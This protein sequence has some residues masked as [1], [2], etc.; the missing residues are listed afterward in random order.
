MSQRPGRHFTWYKNAWNLHILI[1]NF[2]RS[3]MCSLYSAHVMS[4]HVTTAY[5]QKTIIST[6]ITVISDH[7]SHAQ[8]LF[9]IHKIKM[10]TKC[11]C[12]FCNSTSSCLQ[13]H[14]SSAWNLSKL[15]SFPDT[16]NHANSFNWLGKQM[17]LLICLNDSIQHDHP[18]YSTLN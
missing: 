14:C 13:D 6:Y 10:P 15:L 17:K 1:Q 3:G 9:F 12:D 2:E 16:C 8:G 7:H 4:C 18:K 5:L 11:P